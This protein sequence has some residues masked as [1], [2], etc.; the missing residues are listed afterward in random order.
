MSNLEKKADEFLKNFEEY[1]VV[2]KRMTITP[3]DVKPP[4]QLGGFDASVEGWEEGDEV[5]VLM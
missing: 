3:Q 5:Q 4:E 2:E 1:M